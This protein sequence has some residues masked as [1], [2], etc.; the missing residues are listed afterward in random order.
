MDAIAERQTGLDGQAVSDGPSAG[1]PADEPEA[2]EGGSP[3]LTLDGFTGPLD[4][5]LTLA[6]AQ[7]ID[8]AALSLTALIDQLTTALHH[9]PA[10]TSLGEK[11]DWVVMAAWL[12][13]LRTRLLLPADTSS[14]QAATAE[15]DQLRGRLVA[16]EEIQALAGWLE[17]RPHVGR[18][19]FVRGRPELFGIAVEAGP[20]IDVIEFLWASL[21]LFDDEA[22]TDTT[23]AYR[24]APLQLHTVAEARARILRRLAEQPHGVALDQ[25]LPGE[26][27]DVSEP[28]RRARLRRSGWAATFMAGLELAR[29]GEVVL[30]QGGDFEP[31]HIAPAQDPPPP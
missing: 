6:R 5:L 28:S 2:G 20:A 24:P 8:I 22:P 13:Q 23:T 4:H 18:D 16:L 30:G 26:A 1:P 9:A 19:V 25:L 11:G 10:A 7:K 31:I 12:V 29:Q 27:P 3:F 17:R 15:A 14:Q 21:A